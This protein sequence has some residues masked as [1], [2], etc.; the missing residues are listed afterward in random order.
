MKPVLFIS[1]VTFTIYQLKDDAQCQRFVDL[2]IDSMIKD[3][4][5]M[6]MAV[7]SDVILSIWQDSAKCIIYIDSLNLHKTPDNF[8]DGEKRMQ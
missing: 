6:V 1:P 3:K 4:L 5:V 7:N 2:N 8:T